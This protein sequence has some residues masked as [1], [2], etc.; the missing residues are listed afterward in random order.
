MTITRETIN[1]A[2]KR[3]QDA[4]AKLG[5]LVHQITQARTRAHECKRL[6]EDRKVP[7]PIDAP[8]D[9]H[10]AAA[11]EAGGDY[12][13]YQ[14]E[15]RYWAEL[16]K[17]LTDELSATRLAVVQ[18]EQD[19]L[20][21]SAKFWDDRFT[22]QARAFFERN[23]AELRDLFGTLAKV[24]GEEP[25]MPGL[26]QAISRHVPEDVETYRA[27][28]KATDKILPALPE[29][30]NLHGQARGAAASILAGQAD[31]RLHRLLGSVGIDTSDAALAAAQQRQRGEFVA[32]SAA[33][34]KLLQAKSRLASLEA[35]LAACKHSGKS[36]RVDELSEKVS[37]AKV[38]CA[39]L[40]SAV[41][42]RQATADECKAEIEAIALE[43]AK[44]AAV[45]VN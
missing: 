2:C 34:S 36:D 23:K 31:E 38:E 37:E 27:G 3:L 33:Q 4:D 22:E 13:R 39:R 9:Q 14:G 42:G 43:R 5:K 7:V 15:R 44:L 40:D 24:I 28:V 20:S 32:I 41:K 18:A 12:A 6:A 8:I 19:C 1:A 17:R 11:S 21:L 45:E 16:H 10:L 35:D 25:S 30:E 26:W 29:A